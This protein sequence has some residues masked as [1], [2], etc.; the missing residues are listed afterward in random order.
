MNNGVNFLYYVP[1]LIFLLSIISSQK[2]DQVV[3]VLLVIPIMWG[4]Q[5]ENYFLILLFGIILLI[6]IF[7]SYQKVS[8]SE[9]QTKNSLRK[10]QLTKFNQQTILVV[11]GFNLLLL[12]YF[13]IK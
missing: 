9:T 13:L 3:V 8:V 2:Y 6:S 1:L 7:E 12:K 10:I 5:I 11:S 4:I